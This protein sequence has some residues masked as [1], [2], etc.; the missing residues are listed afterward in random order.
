[1]KSKG[2]TISG[3][4]LILL[5]LLIIYLKFYTF[6]HINSFLLL[7]GGL[8][9]AGYFYKKA[10]GFLIPGCLL[11]SLALTSGYSRFSSIANDGPWGLGLGFIAIFLIDLI[12][13]GRTHWWPLIPGLILIITGI[14]RV[15]FLLAKGWPVII[16]L[17][18]I[19]IIIKSLGFGSSREYHNL[20]D[21]SNAED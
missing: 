13:R 18:G 2:Q 10:Y 1:M 12:Y 17:L 21:D 15:S 7:I 11:L 20:E 3:I 16:I 19:Y 5:G 4:I 6:H 9:L 8:F 14:R